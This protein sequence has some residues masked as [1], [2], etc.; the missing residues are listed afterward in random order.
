MK[1]WQNKNQTDLFPIIEND[2]RLVHVL[3][4]LRDSLSEVNRNAQLILSI[5]EHNSVQFTSMAIKDRCVWIVWGRKLR[6]YKLSSPLVDFET[7]IL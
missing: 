1:S 3:E 4:I 7:V 6:V 5:I 2:S